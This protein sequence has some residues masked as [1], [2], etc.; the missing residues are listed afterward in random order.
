MQEN[1]NQQ[2]TNNKQQLNILCYLL[3]DNPLIYYKYKSA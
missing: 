2:T 3:D 1:S